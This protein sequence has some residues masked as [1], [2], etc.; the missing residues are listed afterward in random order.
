[1]GA[2][3]AHMHMRAIKPTSPTWGQRDF[4]MVN[5]TQFMVADPQGAQANLERK[6]RERINERI[7][8]GQEHMTRYS[9]ME[10]FDRTLAQTDGL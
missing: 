7:R 5:T 3:S 10:Q 4:W 9:Q 1:M 2:W 6:G 8:R